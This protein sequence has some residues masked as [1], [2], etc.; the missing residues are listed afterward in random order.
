MSE[1]P[2]PD[3]P[4]IEI[5]G[6]QA[7][8]HVFSI[9][10][11]HQVRDLDQR[12]GVLLEIG[13]VWSE[14]SPAVDLPDELAARW[15]GPSLEQ[16][17][18]QAYRASIPL[19]VTVP[20]L[21]PSQAAELVRESSCVTATVVVA[22]ADVDNDIARVAAVREALGAK[23]RLRID[24]AGQW[25]V[26][27]ALERLSALAQFNL[28]FVEQPVADTDQMRQLRQ[29]LTGRG[30]EIPIAADEI[31][32][33]A[34]E[35]PS[36]AEINQSADFAVLKVQPLGGVHKA[37]EIAEA[38]ALPCVISSTCETSIGLHAG[39][40][41]AACL[42]TLRLSNELDTARLLAADVV[43]RPIASQYGAVRVA[44][45]PRA[46]RDLIDQV[47]ADEQKQAWW[48]DRLRRCAELV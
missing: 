6:Q 12:E 2:N 23:G 14:W 29:E 13:G 20:A 11:R 30:L 35:L 21:A 28:E 4:T 16:G 37:V 42:P 45:R 46:E 8:A 18:P 34:A 7:T 43:S 1:F 9:P 44:G 27:E 3:L 48:L 5:A 31:I 17:M 19:S 10:L 41:A 32:N 47:R 15:L 25:S 36:A 22:D 38:L 33:D 40:R 24:A 26:A 39:V